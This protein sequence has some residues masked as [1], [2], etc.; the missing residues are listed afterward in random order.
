MAFAD[1]SDI[2]T[3]ASVADRGPWA[4]DSRLPES[5]E[6]QFRTGGVKRSLRIRLPR[7]IRGVC[8]FSS[9]TRPRKPLPRRSGPPSPA[10]DDTMPRPDKVQAVA[11][12]KQYFDDSSAAFLTEF[13][14]VKVEHQQELRRSLREAGARYKVLKLTLTRRA[15]QELGH[16]GLDEWLAGPTAVAFV[17]DDPVPTAKAL[18]DF[19][20][21]H[22]GLVIKAGLLKDRVIE[23]E[24]V[25]EV[26]TIESREV[27]L[28]SIAGT[29]LGPLARAA[30]LLGSFTRE[31]ASVF[32]QL[33]DKKGS[34]EDGSLSPK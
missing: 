23:P 19:S 9:P 29:L 17:D 15:L 6:E 7:S 26:A 13:R 4:A 22:E 31:A 3:V 32:S 25:A 8:L 28:G 24:R 10:E 5:T 14:G 1:R 18:V 33:L 11:E 12:I 34:A 16:E 27:L 2:L 30:F 21:Q 20:K